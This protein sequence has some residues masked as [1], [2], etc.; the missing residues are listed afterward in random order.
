MYISGL[1]IMMA[2]YACTLLPRAWAYYRE[3]AAWRRDW[4]R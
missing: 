1:L 3:C 2:G 4:A